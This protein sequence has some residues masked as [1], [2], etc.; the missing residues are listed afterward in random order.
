MLFYVFRARG[1]W[2]KL[3]RSPCLYGIIYVFI[4]RVCVCQLFNFKLAKLIK[5]NNINFNKNVKKI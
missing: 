2:R 3:L 4:F 5:Q 1:N